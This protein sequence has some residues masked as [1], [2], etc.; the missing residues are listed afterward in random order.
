MYEER[1]EEEEESRQATEESMEKEP[2][3][4]RPTT[5][6]EDELKPSAYA[7]SEEQLPVLS[8]MIRKQT[9]RRMSILK[10]R[11]PAEFTY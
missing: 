3:A 11:D 10:G 2:I 4:R 9:M 5:L 6:E 1:K 7:F 8:D